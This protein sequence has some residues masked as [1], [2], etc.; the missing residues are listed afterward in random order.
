[1]CKQ[2]G[3]A[4]ANACI[5]GGMIGALVGVKSIPLYMINKVINYDCSNYKQHGG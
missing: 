2:G 1:M 4:D 3:D 5:A